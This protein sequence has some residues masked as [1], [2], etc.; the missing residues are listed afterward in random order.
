LEGLRLLKLNFDTSDIYEKTVSA[1]CLQIKL[2][3]PAEAIA[4]IFL[5]G[6]SFSFAAAVM[7]QVPD[8]AKGKACVCAKCAAAGA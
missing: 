1:T 5:L 4:L 2:L 3:I 6:S 7:D 8:S